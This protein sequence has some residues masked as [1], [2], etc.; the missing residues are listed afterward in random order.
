M[1]ESLNAEGFG[2]DSENNAAP[3][4]PKG[5]LRREDRND[6]THEFTEFKSRLSGGEKYA[7]ALLMY[8]KYGEK[9]GNVKPTSTVYSQSDDR[10][11]NKS[12]GQ[13]EETPGGSWEK[14][15]SPLA[16]LYSRYAAK[17]AKEAAKDE[18]YKQVEE[19]TEI[20]PDD[21][22][23]EDY[24]ASFPVR[25]AVWMDNPEMVRVGKSPI[26]SRTNK[27]WEDFYLP[28]EWVETFGQ[29]DIPVYKNNEEE[30]EEEEETEE[31]SGRGNYDNL[32]QEDSD[33]FSES[34]KSQ[35]RAVDIEGLNKKQRTAAIC[36]EVPEARGSLADEKRKFLMDVTNSG[37]STVYKGQDLF[38]ESG[39]PRTE[40]EEESDDEQEEAEDETMTEDTTEDTEEVGKAA[41]YTKLAI[42]KKPER[43]LE[44][45]A[46]DNEEMVL[47]YVLENHEAELEEEFES[48]VDEDEVV[49]EMLQGL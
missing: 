23:I 5:V 11:P 15:E 38:Q 17:K 44:L 33:A 34:I 31:S 45:L 21:V 46:E 10:F 39:D 20:N 36:S 35:I 18:F 1:S 25:K 37:S 7:F 28:V 43:V 9:M 26:E 29:K 13:S 3:N 30:E 49:D 14:A 42:Q 48:E 12:I 22:T 32:G 40:T 6:E 2:S 24:K 27:Q 41:K 19:E 16:F 4:T 8:A 47:D